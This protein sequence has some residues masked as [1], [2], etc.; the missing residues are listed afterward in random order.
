MGNCKN[1]K[2]NRYIS[3]KNQYCSA[4]CYCIATGDKICGVD[5]SKLKGLRMSGIEE[6]KV[7]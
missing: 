6:E 5:M 4:K 1:N 3:D 2:C 7:E